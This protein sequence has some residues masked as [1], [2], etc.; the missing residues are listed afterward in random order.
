[1]VQLSGSMQDYNVQISLHIAWLFV[2]VGI[3]V[4]E[5]SALLN[6]ISGT[7]PAPHCVNEK[8]QKVK[9][10]AAGSWGGEMKEL[11]SSAVPVLKFLYLATPK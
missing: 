7:K 8:I 2:C 10:V 6:A 4:R 3:F 1:M 11:F 5:E 9:P